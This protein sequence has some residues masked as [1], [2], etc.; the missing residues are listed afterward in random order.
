MPLSSVPTPSHARTAVYW[1]NEDNCGVNGTL[2]EPFTDSSFDFR[3]P[4]NCKSLV[5]AN[6]R[7]VGAE[8][9]AFVPL[10]V[11]GGDDQGTY[12]GDSFICPAAIHA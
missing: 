1:T 12:R 8:E 4:A 6:A 7:P 5:L 9:V 3:C 11:G 2:C 10:V